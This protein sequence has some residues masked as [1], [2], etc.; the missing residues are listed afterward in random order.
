MLVCLLALMGSISLH[1]QALDGPAWSSKEIEPSG[2]NTKA[3]PLD[4]YSAEVG[5]VYLDNQ[6]ILGDFKTWITSQPWLGDC[7]YIE[8]INN[9]RS[10]SVRIL[11]HG[12]SKYL[13][14][15]TEEAALRGIA[16]SVEYRKQ[17]RQQSIDAAS[18]IWSLSSRW[19]ALGFVVNS[20]AAIGINEG[21]EVGGTY[22][23]HLDPKNS[24]SLQ[25]V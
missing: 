5:T 8:Q 10:R 3:S 2:F 20:V 11:W 18:R 19:Q 15:I 23:G 17:S 16:A 13:P 9:A 24:Q 14:R 4:I 1:A 6:E 25:D 21:I 22:V 12:D 7:G